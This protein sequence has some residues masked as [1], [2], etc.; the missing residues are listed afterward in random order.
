MTIQEK[1]KIDA[2]AATGISTT[3]IA[4]QTGISRNTIKSY[5]QRQKKQTFCLNC[6]GIL[7]MTPHKKRKKFCCDKCRMQY[8]NKH[9]E[10]MKLSNATEIHCE[11]CGKTVIR[12]RKTPRKYCSHSCAAQGR[13]KHERED[14]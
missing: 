9:P 10:E 3:E 13:K 11:T 14:S 1:T 4:N 12:Y 7:K 2:L 5:L 8:W 6:G